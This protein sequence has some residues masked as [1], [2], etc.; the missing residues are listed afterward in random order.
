MKECAMF[1]S[2]NVEGM[3]FDEQ[4]IAHLPVEQQKTLAGFLEENELKLLRKYTK[5]PHVKACVDDLLDKIA[6]EKLKCK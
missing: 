1:A 4:L 3:A 5:S 6:R 2:F